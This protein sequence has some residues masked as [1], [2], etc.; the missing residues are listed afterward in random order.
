MCRALGLS[1][2]LL[3]VTM[4]SS[5]SSAEP[6]PLTHPFGIHGPQ[7]SHWLGGN[8]PNLWQEAEARLHVVRDTGAGWARQDFWWSVV[9]PAPGRFEWAAFDRAIPSYGRHDLNLLAILCYGSAWSDGRA[10]ETAAER[11]AF[12]RYVY[13]MVDRYQDHVDAWEIWNEPNIQPFWSP[14]PDP[15][16]Y[17]EL[18]KVAYRAAKRADPDC[19]VVGGVTAGPDLNFLRGMYAHGAGDSFDVL[20]YHNYSQVQDLLTEYP[21]VAAIRELMAAHGDA[22]K[23]IWHTESGFYTGPV[24]LSDAEQASRI[25]RYSLGLLALGIDKTFQLTVYDWTDNP[26]HHEV[27]EYRGLTR[28]DYTPKPALRA[29]QFMTRH[30]G[31]RTFAGHVRP[32]AGVWGQLFEDEHGSRVLVLWRD[33]EQPATAVTLA[34]DPV[35]L[36]SDLYGAWQVLREPRGQHVLVIGRDPV[37][38]FEP[39]ANVVNQRHVAFESPIATAVPREKEATLT[40]RVAN[41][42]DEPVVFGIWLGVPGDDTL[43]FESRPI[44]AGATETQTLTVDASRLDVG[45]RDC[46]WRLIHPATEQT[47][48]TGYR[49]ID[50]EP[51][52]AVSFGVLDRLSETTPTLPVEI[53]YAGSEPTQAT[54]QL[55]VGGEPTADPQPVSLEPGATQTVSLPLDLEPVLSGETRSFQAIVNALGLAVAM[56]VERPI[57]PCPRAPANAEIDGDLRE[58]VRRPP[59]VTPDALRWAYVN[60]PTAPAASDLAVMAWTAWDE[61]GLWLAVR[62][63]DDVITLPRGRNV[64][65]WD[66]VQVGLDL[67]S[68]AGSD[69]PY[70]E[71]DLEIELGGVSGGPFWVYFGASPAGWPVD[72]LNRRLAGAAAVDREAGEVYY[73]LL[74]PAAV[75]ENVATL[76]PDR[77]L[78]FSFLVNDNDGTGRAGWQ[79][80]TP[81]IGMGKEPRHFAWLWLRPAGGAKPVD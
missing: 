31:A 76:A 30:I 48:V 59:T 57:I 39:S 45:R 25:V 5:Q 67:A 61:R 19:V 33:W 58:W 23:P 15:K 52:L 80:L 81:G 65:D 47:V 73:E 49:L 70:D 9:E 63:K 50:V 42:F 43:Y 53:A 60:A 21:A 10:P 36:V 11:E 40:V 1:L 38:V 69:E 34:L 66:S 64:W 35:T 78:G 55:L 41:A 22:D 56:P 74:V 8:L 4:L 16:L 20:S 62:V 24:G 17:A 13:A 26:E 2:V 37:Y 32:A 77:V 27:S 75:I 7:Y 79:E 3:S 51:P 68:D 12:G 44:A 46:Q 54:A 14:R 28:M 72:E 6:P 71:N 29:Y 18:L